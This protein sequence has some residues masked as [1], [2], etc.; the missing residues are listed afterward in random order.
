MIGIGIDTGGTC[1]DAVVYDRQADKI[2]FSAKAQTTRHDLKIGICSA[3]EKIP[4][5]LRA[6]AEARAAGGVCGPLYHHGHQRLRR[7]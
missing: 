4:P 6:Q 1:T 2:L 5:A 3:L 7:K